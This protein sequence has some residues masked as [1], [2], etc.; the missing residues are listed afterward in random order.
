MS[1]TVKKL[2]RPFCWESD[3]LNTEAAA[4][5][6]PDVHFTMSRQSACRARCRGGKY[7]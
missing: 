6:S 4:R 2:R 7:T 5:L 1:R 3:A